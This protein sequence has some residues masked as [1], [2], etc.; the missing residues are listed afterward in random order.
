[1]KK[2]LDQDPDLHKTLDSKRRDHLLSLYRDKEILSRIQV[3]EEEIRQF[4]DRQD[5]TR[6][7]RTT[8]ILVRTR[9][10]AQ[11]D[12]RPPRSRE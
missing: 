9:E 3:S 12:P 6:E 7:R 8:A 1:M 10:Q 5:M 11:A 4:F 2:D